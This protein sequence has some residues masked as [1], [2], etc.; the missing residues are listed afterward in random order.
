MKELIAMFKLYSVQMIALLAV[1]NSALAGVDNVPAWLVISINVLGA[2][3]GY[4]ARKAPQ[5]EVAA[6]LKAIK[7]IP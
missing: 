1:I 3:A 7:A 5:P 2:V 4:F 6:E